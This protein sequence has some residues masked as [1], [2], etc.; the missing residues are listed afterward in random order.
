MDKFVNHYMIQFSINQTTC[1][2]IGLSTETTNSK[3][4]NEGTQ[5]PSQ[6]S[7]FKI[8]KDPKGN[9]IYLSKL[10][11]RTY[12]STDCRSQS[13]VHHCTFELSQL[14]AQYSFPSIQYILLNTVLDDHFRAR[15]IN[16]PNFFDQII[17]TNRTVAKIK[18]NRLN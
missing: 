7:P 11:N 4:R 8:M 5:S 13:S 12:H 1:Q 14:S 3:K 15:T 2:S 18:L 9:L 10:P 17:L 16:N 6:V